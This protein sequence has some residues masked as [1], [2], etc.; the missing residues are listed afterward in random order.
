VWRLEYLRRKAREWHHKHPERS[1]ANTKK[2]YLENKG[3]K[4]SR[5]NELFKVARANDPGTRILLNFRS[6]L[7]TLIHRGEAK[8]FSISKGILLY[9][10]AELRAH[11]EKQ[12]TP[13]MNWANYAKYWEVDHIK[14]CARFDLTDLQQCR[15]C[16]ALKNLRPLEITTNRSRYCAARRKAKS[17]LPNAI[18]SAARA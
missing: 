9:T 16:F 3:R 1:R 7:S 14:E 2:Y 8:T 5:R 15:E 13:Q 10:G 4:N 18:P 12:F 11:L 17:A 6:R